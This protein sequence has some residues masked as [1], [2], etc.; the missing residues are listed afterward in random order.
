[1]KNIWAAILCALVI[2]CA[3]KGEL[4]GH[5][6]ILLDAPQGMEITLGFD[7]EGGKFYGRAVNNYFGSYTLDANKIKFSMVGST[8]MAAPEPL[9]NAETQYFK[10]LSEVSEITFDGKKIVLSNGDAKMVFE[11]AEGIEN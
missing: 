1:M 3:P 6:Y 8:M 7:G 4:K 11:Q 5:D 2:G 9:M 10:A